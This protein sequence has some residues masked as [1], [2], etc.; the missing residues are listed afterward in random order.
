M[1]GLSPHIKQLK[2]KLDPITP[3]R[4]L[5]PSISAAVAV[6]PQCSPPFKKMIQVIFRQV[7]RNITPI[8]KIQ[9][10]K[11][12]VSTKMKPGFF[13]AFFVWMKRNDGSNARIIKNM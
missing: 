10:T 2:I 8:S 1:G 7:M 4:Y 12:H 5:I 9:A 11:A 13:V 3:V 6:R